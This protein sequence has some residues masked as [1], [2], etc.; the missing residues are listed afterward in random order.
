MLRALPRFAL[1]ALMMLLLAA[2]AG[3]SIDLSQTYTLD[4]EL[5]GTI[6]VRYPSGWSVTQTF[7]TITFFNQ[8]NVETLDVTTVQE[9]LI[10]GVV[11]PV[12][13]NDPGRVMTLGEV[14]DRMR[15]EPTAAYNP[16]EVNING[17]AVLTAEIPRENGSAEYWMISEI[18]AGTYAV[19]VAVATPSTL[20][21]NRDALNAIAAHVDYTE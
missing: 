17:R 3:S 10:T 11:N 15:K 5:G 4:N 9:G 8:E 14:L 1:L 7:S 20:N 21:E 2:C 12:R 19:L 18:R 6:T 16:A 13:L